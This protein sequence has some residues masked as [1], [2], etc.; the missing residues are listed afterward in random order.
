MVGGMNSLY[1]VLLALVLGVGCGESAE[2]KAAKARA[3]AKADVPNSEE[4]SHPV[5]LSPPIGLAGVYVS[6]VYVI[7][8]YEQIL[9][10]T[11]GNDEKPSDFTMLVLSISH[12]LRDNVPFFAPLHKLFQGDLR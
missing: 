9:R 12:M 4:T 6:V 7:P 11:L 8:K 2:E 1:A 5:G 3:E 10:D